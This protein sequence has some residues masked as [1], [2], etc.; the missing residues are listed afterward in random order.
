MQKQSLSHS[1]LP[2]IQFVLRSL[3]HNDRRHLGPLWSSSPFGVRRQA[4]VTGLRHVFMATSSFSSSSFRP[5]PPPPLHLPP[6]S[7]SSSFSRRCKG[8][9]RAFI[10]RWTCG[11]NPVLEYLLKDVLSVRQLLV[12][13]VPERWGPYSERYIYRLWQEGG[14][15]QSSYFFTVRV[16]ACLPLCVVLTRS[17]RKGWIVPSAKKQL[18]LLTTAWHPMSLPFL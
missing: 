9:Q 5:L 15:E 12:D 4:L 3:K 6:S 14:V 2:S 7:S 13:V 17:S 18:L 16:C 10:R 1:P 11:L 8:V